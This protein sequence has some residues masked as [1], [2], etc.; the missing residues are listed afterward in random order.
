MWRGRAR[1][2]STYTSPLPNADSASERASWNERAKSSTS[3]RDAHALAAA[4]GGR[5]D[6][7][8]EADLLRELERLVDVVDAAGR[9]GHDRDADLDHLLA[10]RALSP[11]KRICSAVG[12]MN[13]MFDAAQMSANSAFSAR[14]P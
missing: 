3:L 7:D 6:D 9:A 11:I 13:A 10:R 8:R 1:Y 14:K 12:P 2:F 4:A 5:L